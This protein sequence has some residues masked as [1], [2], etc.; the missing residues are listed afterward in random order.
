MCDVMDRAEICPLHAPSM[1]FLLLGNVGALSTLGT[2]LPLDRLPNV[3]PAA[4]H[5][6]PWG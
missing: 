6:A 5:G 3:R 1:W 2:P 4:L